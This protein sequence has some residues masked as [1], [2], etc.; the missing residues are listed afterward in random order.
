MSIEKDNFSISNNLAGSFVRNNVL[1]PQHVKMYGY[2]S[3]ST[4]KYIGQAFM[5]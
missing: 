2:L 1:I 4:T 3:T 5:L